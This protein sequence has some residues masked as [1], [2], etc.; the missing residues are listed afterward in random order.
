MRPQ[1]LP[2]LA[3]PLLLL[4]LLLLPPPPCP[5]HSATRFDPTW[6]SLDAR[7]LPAWFD[8]AKFGI[9]I[10]WGVFSVPSFGSEWFWWYWQKEKI[11]KYVEFMKD[12]YPP[13]FKYEDFGPLFTAKFFNANQWADIFQASG[14]KYI[15]LTS[16]HHEATCRD[17]FMWRKSF[18]EYWAHTRWHHF[19]SF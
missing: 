3:F 18:D 1:E 4:L 7:Q 14:A 8:Q 2:R 12:N 9:F 10:H 5:A 13:S 6:E 19:C 16:K 15:V 11:P 17:S